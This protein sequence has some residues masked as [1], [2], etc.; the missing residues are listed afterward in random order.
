MNE[1]ASQCTRKIAEGLP[2]WK[3]VDARSAE[4]QCGLE[5]TLQ[6][7]ET[8]WLAAADIRHRFYI[9]GEQAIQLLERDLPGIVNLVNSDSRPHET[10]QKA[11]D[12]TAGLISIHVMRLLYDF[13]RP[14]QGLP[15]P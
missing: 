3:H 14:I 15:I 11:F 1:L 12:D 6:L 4:L 13:Y 9:R 7:I 5:A 8:R 2:H 10:V